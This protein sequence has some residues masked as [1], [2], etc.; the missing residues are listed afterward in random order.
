MISEDKIRSIAEKLLS[1]EKNEDENIEEKSHSGL[2]GI[3]NPKDR[4]AIEGFLKTTPARICVGRAGD[5]P[6]TSSYLQFQ[7]DHAKAVDSV[8]NDVNEKILKDLNIV[9]LKSK[10][11]SKDQHLTRPDLGRELDEESKNILLNNCEKSPKVQVIVS[12]GLSSKAV[13]ANIKDLLKSFIQGLELC[14]IKIGTPVYV[15]YGRVGV[16]DVIGE[17][18]N[19]ECAVIFIG[20]RPGMTTAESISAYITYKPRRG[21][22]ESERTVL[23]NIHRGGTPPVEAGA[24]IASIVK[25]ALDNKKS[26]IKL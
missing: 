12:D 17:Y 1:E 4:E 10:V 22:L 24:E 23:S 20:E 16:M 25:E 14:G 3:L 15:K 8:F 18:L 19:A 13:E 7:I 9:L 6:T 11:T 21:I 26:G 5:R 2:I